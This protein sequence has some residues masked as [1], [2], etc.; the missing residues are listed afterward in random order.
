[1]KSAVFG[2]FFGGE[3]ITTA[4]SRPFSSL[5]DCQSPGCFFPS[6]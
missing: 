3:P 5:S 6:T 1:V 4:I 2:I